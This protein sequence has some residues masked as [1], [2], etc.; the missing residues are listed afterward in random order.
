MSLPSTL[1]ALSPRAFRIR[2]GIVVLIGAIAG[3]AVFLFPPVGQDPNYHKFA[4]GRT[5]MG[6]P[7]ML[8]VVSNVPFL[9]FGIMGIWAT[10]RQTQVF[11]SRSERWPYFVLFLGVTLTAFGS[12]WYHLDPTNDRLVWD[13][14]PM[15]VAFMAFFATVIAERIDRRVGLGLLIP[16]LLLGIG[17]VWWWHV[18]EQRGQ[19]DMRPYILVQLIPI[20][21]APVMLLI[22][23]SCYTGTGW[24]WAALG[25]Y[26]LA[27][28]L[29]MLLDER[30]YQLG[31][32]VSGH[33]LKHLAAALGAYCIYR[34]ARTR[35][36]RQPPSP[37]APLPKG[38]GSDV[39]P[40]AI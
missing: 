10:A 15:T 36:N 1:P 11:V 5:L 40:E 24:I 2:V 38:E 20:V 31:H 23:P 18:T 26:L 19:G 17:S 32:V 35:G 7:H 8:N 33:T 13:R 25:W 4:D 27:K 37:P 22:L 3:G 39:P 9:I 21:V 30:I 29:E 34:M 12:S 14:L 6:V 28:V 16:L